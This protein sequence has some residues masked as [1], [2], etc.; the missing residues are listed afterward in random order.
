V[1]S[2]WAFQQTGPTCRRRLWGTNTVTCETKTIFKKICSCF[3]LVSIFML[4]LEI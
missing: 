3:M 1:P 4:C 2:A